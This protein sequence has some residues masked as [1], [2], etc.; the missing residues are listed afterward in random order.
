MSKDYR[1]DSQLYQQLAAIKPRIDFDDEWPEE[2]PPWV[3]D[4]APARVYHHEADMS[5][6]STTEESTMTTTTATVPTSDTLEQFFG[7]LGQYP[8]NNVLERCIQTL[9]SESARAAEFGDRVEFGDDI[10]H[11]AMPEGIQFDE[12]GFPKGAID[13]FERPAPDTTDDMGRTLSEAQFTLLT[14]LRDDEVTALEMAA[15]LVGVYEAINGEKPAYGIVR[16]P[17]GRWER[18]TDIH[19]ALKRDYIRARQNWLRKQAEAQDSRHSRFSAEGSETIQ[20][21][22]RSQ[23][24]KVLSAF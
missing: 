8:R 7:Q 24:A 12:A 1:Q 15:E 11:Q 3:D 17:A 9:I 22:V 5:D 2:T 18:I 20:Q 6:T 14:S 13:D 23:R 21:Q 19:H 4:P 10:A 16:T